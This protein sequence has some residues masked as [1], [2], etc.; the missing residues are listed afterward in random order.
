MNDTTNTR[1]RHGGRDGT[2]VLS[3]VTAVAPI[4]A[5]LVMLVVM[6]VERRW[7]FAMMVVPGLIG[8]GA[9]ALLA[10]A[11]LSGERRGK[12]AEP[13]HSA[14]GD[15]TPS[16]A[17]CAEDDP[18]AVFASI[19]PR[20][21]ESLALPNPRDEPLPWRYVVRRWLEPPC[22][23]ATLGMGQDGPFRLDLARQGPHALVAGTTGSGKSVLLQTWC[24]SLACRNPPDRLHFV[25]LDFKG[26]SAFGA[27]AR[28]PHVAG[29]V[30]DLDLAH[31]TRALEAIEGELRRRERLVADQ[32][33]ADVNRMAEPPP[34]LMIVVDEFHALRSQLPDYVDR[35][36]RIAALG[37]SLGMH[38]IACTQN[39]QGQVGADMKANIAV[40][41][42]LRVRDP[43]QSRELLGSSRA[44]AISPSLP[45]AAYCADGESIEALRCCE[46]RDIDAAVDAVLS[47]QRFCELPSAEPLF[48]APLPRVADAETAS[49][50]VTAAS[51]AVPFAVSDNGVRLG[52]AMLPVMSGNVAIIGQHGR[53]KSTVL[54][55]VASMLRDM[56]T[57]QLRT[58]RR[59]AR[60]TASSIVRG[61]SH[62][63]PAG[64]FGTAAPGAPPP[65]HPRMVW[66][67]D[68]ADPLLD[69]LGDDPLCTEFRAALHD[70]T[71]TVIFAARTMRHVRVPEHCTTRVIF[72]TGDRPTDLTSGIPP[73]LLARFTHEDLDTP[74]RAVL[75]DKGR[76]MPVQCFRAG[77]PAIP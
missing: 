77:A 63:H 64:E 57:V 23:E 41:I 1:R 28:M 61:A 25:F 17:E 20:S 58:S 8:C 40:N 22:M 73:D 53:G 5:Q 45:G 67:A 44:A 62:A 31:A 24:L 59:S 19:E 30:C 60:G 38:L 43:M 4:G 65:P 32:H 50:T 71:V 27:L 12:A 42:C 35:L 3:A 66:L 75:V 26:G 54:S 47:A 69:P 49:R 48:S 15:G 21:W 14:T 46:A 36:V 70:P 18:R 51:D 76:A 52:T 33:V 56:P 13:G 6:L 37:R 7:M 55:V 34:R 10:L 68:D 9:S 29:N 39:P 16:A 74:G 11:R 2:R 72:P